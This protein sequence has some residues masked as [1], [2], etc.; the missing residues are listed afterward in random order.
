MDQN[1]NERLDYKW[2]WL[3]VPMGPWSRSEDPMRLMET[4]WGDKVEAVEYAEQELSLEQ[5]K[6]SSYVTMIVKGA[7][8]EIG[9]KDG[10][11]Q[12]TGDLVE[13]GVGKV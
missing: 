1:Q 9:R 10:G 3:L 6:G 11:E 13:K 12:K 4:Q 2:Q 7:L 8:N 5:L